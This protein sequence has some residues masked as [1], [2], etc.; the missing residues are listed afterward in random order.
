[1]S[2]CACRRLHK[3]LCV[4]AACF[5]EGAI[6]KSEQWGSGRFA[7]VL[8]PRSVKTGK[9][10][11]GS[12]VLFYVVLVLVKETWLINTALLHC[13]QEVQ[14]CSWS[15]D[16]IFL[17]KSR[18]IKSYEQSHNRCNKSAQCVLL[19]FSA[20]S[21]VLKTTSTLQTHCVL[22]SVYPDQVLTVRSSISAEIF[23]KFICMEE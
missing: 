22:H 15:L 21:E 5:V 17:L 1:M 10:I 19:V 2:A 20:E 12:R 7:G 4:Y 18:W 23:G 9:T 13:V 8:N 3:T 11:E 14:V 6:K 16:H